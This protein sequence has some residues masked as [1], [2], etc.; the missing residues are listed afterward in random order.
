ML[1]DPPVHFEALKKQAGGVLLDCSGA[2]LLKLDEKKKM[3]K[4]FKKKTIE[5]KI[6]KKNQGL[7]QN[8]AC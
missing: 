4:V 8:Q 2:S 6:K 7:K 1:V 5:K 3:T